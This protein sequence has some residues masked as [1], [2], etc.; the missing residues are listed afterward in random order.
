MNFLSNFRT[1]RLCKNTKKVTVDACVRI[2]KTKQDVL[3]I[4]T[5]CGI[6]QRARANAVK[7]R[8]VV[9]DLAST[10][11]LAGEWLPVPS[12]RSRRVQRWKFFSWRLSVVFLSDANVCHKNF[13]NSPAK[14]RTIAQQK[15]NFMKIPY[16]W[17]IGNIY[18]V[19]V[20]QFDYVHFWRSITYIRF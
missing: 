18:R 5:G 16:I 3:K 7:Y 13:A 15:F 12:W 19:E 11:P 17:Y 2:E 20:H 9:Q 14:F 8:I 1:A 4:R 10:R 6:H